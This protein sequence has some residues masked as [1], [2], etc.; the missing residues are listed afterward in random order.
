MGGVSSKAARQFPKTAKPSKPTWAGA[1]T[2]E[3]L[4]EAPS[5]SRPSIPR[6]SEIKTE[7]ILQDSRDPQLAANLSKLG[8]V[9]VDH[10][11]HSIPVAN[12]VDQVFRSRLQS[13]SQARSTHSTRNRLLAS[14]LTELLGD[15]KNAASMEDVNKLAKT[16]NMDT[17][18]ILSLAKYITTP[19]VDQSSVT[20]T[21]DN[22]GVE[23]ISM[24]SFTIL[25]WLLYSERTSAVLFTYLPMLT[26]CATSLT[27]FAAGDVV[28]QQFIEKKGKDHDFLRTAR[29]GFYGGAMFG[30]ILTKWFQFLNRLKFSSP[31]RGVAYRVYLDQAVFTPVMVGFFF[32]SMTLLEGQGV[33]EATERISEA[34]APT[35][36]RNW[37]VF[38]PT[39]IINFSIVPHHLRFVV[40][41]VVSLFWNTYLSAVNA[42]TQ[43]EQSEGH[44]IEQIHSDTKEID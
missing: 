21:V 35:I 41:G 9:R 11:M 28:A 19:S 13:E 24:K 27:L 34:Y 31:R 22:Q 10:H 3:P 43:A 40:V 30:P 33:S 39:Q 12:Q 4:P 20:R 44:R 7:A 36:I 15:L 29:L 8:A 25:V 14:S 16:H 37:G 26:Q 5:T 2:G 17:E 18:R 6:A 1:R 23:R 42:R 32:G 38:I